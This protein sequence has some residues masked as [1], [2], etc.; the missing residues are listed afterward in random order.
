MRRYYAAEF[1]YI[2]RIYFC[3]W[4]NNLVDMNDTEGLCIN[5]GRILYFDRMEK[6]KHYCE[7]HEM[8]YIDEPTQYD[9]VRI[10]QWVREGTSDDID[11]DLLLIFW[12]I[13]IDLAATL[14]LDFIGNDDE[15]DD[16]YSKLF[17]GNNLPTINTSGK[18]YIPMW[19]EEEVL[20][21][22][23]VIGRGV[24]MFAQCFGEQGNSINF[25]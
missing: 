17:A 9:M 3:I 10:Q 4:Y 6:L 8:M 5:N 22:K 7:T 18:E 11:C 13:V 12:N 2:D 25:S 21:L 16:V 1:K 19:S 14:K 23:Q 15:Y 20:Q 24:I